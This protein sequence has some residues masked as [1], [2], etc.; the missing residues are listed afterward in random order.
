MLLRWSRSTINLPWDVVHKNWMPPFWIYSTRVDT[1]APSLGPLLNVKSSWGDA[2]NKVKNSVEWY[3]SKG[4][5]FRCLY[6]FRAIFHLSCTIITKV[7]LFGYVIYFSMLLFSDKL[8]I[9]QSQASRPCMPYHYDLCHT[10][11]C[12]S[13]RLDANVMTFAT[14]ESFP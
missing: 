10:L 11:S 3:N 4:H 5:C 7:S 1:W 9:M 8:Q 12:C 6:Y 2:H 13:F 14:D